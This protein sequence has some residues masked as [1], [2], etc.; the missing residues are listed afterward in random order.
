MLLIIRISSKFKKFL[1]IEIQIWWSRKNIKQNLNFFS[2]I[3]KGLK[4]LKWDQDHHLQWKWPTKIQSYY[5][6]FHINHL[7][8]E[9]KKSDSYEGSNSKNESFCSKDYMVSVGSENDIN[10]N[11][12]QQE[13]SPRLK[14]KEIIEKLRSYYDK[15]YLQQKS[16]QKIFLH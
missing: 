15:E 14:Q 2:K 7:T 12:S 11:E 9:D 3:L 1:R 6:T 8:E 4:M 13:V 10:E 5:Q 16:P